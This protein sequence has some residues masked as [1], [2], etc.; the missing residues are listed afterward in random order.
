MP[1]PTETSA[2]MANHSRVCPARRAALVTSRRLAMLATMARK[3]SGGTMARSRA[4]K[5]R[6]DRGQGRG[7]PVVG[8]GDGADLAGDEAED[9]AEDETDEDLHAER[10]ARE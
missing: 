1:M 10:D 4:T 6:A 8:L 5:E 7:Q 3:T 2:V 9:H